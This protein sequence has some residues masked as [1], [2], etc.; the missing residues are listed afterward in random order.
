M[1]ERINRVALH[2][3]QYVTIDIQRHAHSGVPEHLRHHFRMDTA[4][5]QEGGGGVSQIVEANGRQSC[6]GQQWRKVP[7]QDV[8][9]TDRMSDGV[10]E[11]ASLILPCL[12]GGFAQG[13]LAG[14][15]R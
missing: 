1:I 13:E 5:E 9:P 7:L 2:I 14:T 11:D 6:P 12:F 10:G 4:K 8:V 15:V 3:W